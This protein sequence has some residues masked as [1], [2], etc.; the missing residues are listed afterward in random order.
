MDAKILP[1]LKHLAV[2]LD[3]VNLDRSNP[4]AHPPENLETI[5]LSL[6]QRGR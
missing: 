5:Q 4:R 3:S 1:Q 2:P 6:S